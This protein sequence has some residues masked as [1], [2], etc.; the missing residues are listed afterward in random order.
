MSLDK[1][2]YQTKDPRKMGLLNK[3]MDLRI[4]VI[5]QIQD[6]QMYFAQLCLISALLPNKIKNLDFYC[7]IRT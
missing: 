4:L 3:R 1:I 5:F 7:S 6:S 2:T